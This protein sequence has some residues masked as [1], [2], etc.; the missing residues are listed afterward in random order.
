MAKITENGKKYLQLTDNILAEYT[1]AADA[2]D[3]NG[4]IDDLLIGPD[5]EGVYGRAGAAEPANRDKY[6]IASSGYNNEIYFM[7]GVESSGV[8]C[9]TLMNTVLPTRKDATRWAETKQNGSGEYYA[10]YDSKWCKNMDTS[11]AENS[12]M[13]NP[14]NTEYIPYD[15]LRLY[16]QSGYHSEYDGFIINLYTKNRPGDYVNLLSVIYHNTGDL[17]VMSEPMWFADKIYTSY[18]EYR[19]PST[20]YLSSDCI[21]GLTPSMS[22]PTANGWTDFNRANPKD[23][24]G[25]HTLPYYISSGK[26]FYSNPAIGIDLHAVTGYEDSHGFRVYKTRPLVSTIFPNK[27]SY[28]RLFAS[29]RPAADGDYY[30]IYGYYENNPSDPVYDDTSLY[31]YLSRFDGKFSIAHIVTVTETCTD[32]DTNESYSVAH[33]PM[34]YIQTW[35]MLENAVKDGSSPVIKFRPVLEHTADMTGASISYTMRIMSDR[36]G[37]SIIKSGSCDIVNPRRFGPRTVNAVLN[38]VNSVR[39]YNRITPSPG[40]NVTETVSPVAAGKS[41]AVVVNKYV[42]SS[43]IDRRNIR[44]SVSPVRIDNVE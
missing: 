25:E 18:I 34:T 27:D 30:N 33:A 38:S 37:T 1:Y 12:L 29:V 14:E 39:V 23:A 3:G 16:F 28:D 36:D 17:K 22:S 19:V 21:G 44:V 7:N 15:M 31:K 8:T 20:A 13:S 9:N 32:T 42:T 35:E 26:G 24:P 4:D 5:G 40:I 2:W 10:D 43:F 41:G 6:V 11:D